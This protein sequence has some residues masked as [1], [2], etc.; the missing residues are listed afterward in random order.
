MKILFFLLTLV[1]AGHLQAKD[2]QTSFAG[3]GFKGT[4]TD[5]YTVNGK[6]WAYDKEPGDRNANTR[7]Q[8]KLRAAC[9]AGASDAD[10]RSRGFRTPRAGEY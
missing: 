2:C 7:I 4:C 8:E 9:N 1:A 5:V 6:K 10:F 3:G